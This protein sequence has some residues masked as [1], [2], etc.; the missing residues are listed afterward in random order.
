MINKFLNP[1]NSSVEIVE[2]VGSLDF[3]TDI[4]KGHLESN[5]EVGLIYKSLDNLISNL[6]L[7]MKT[8][9]ESVKTNKEVNDE[10]LSKFSNLL[11]NTVETSSGTQELSASMEKPQNLNFYK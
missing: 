5:T 9:A 8:V 4:D 2:R 10:V 11:E 6:R 1:I 3:S 7:F